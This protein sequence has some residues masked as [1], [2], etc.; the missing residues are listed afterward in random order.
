[1]YVQ[2]L[3]PG[4]QQRILTNNV[5]ELYTVCHLEHCHLRGGGLNSAWVLTCTMLHAQFLCC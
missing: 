1:L 5:S 4:H 3:C 2:L